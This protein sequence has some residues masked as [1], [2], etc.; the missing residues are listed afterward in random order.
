MRCASAS[1]AVKRQ[2]PPTATAHAPEQGPRGVAR[3]ALQR[4][5][6]ALCLPQPLLQVRRLPAQLRLSVCPVSGCRLLTRARLCQG[7]T[8]LGFA[9]DCGRQRLGALPAGRAGGGG[10]GGRVKWH[11]IGSG[12]LHMGRPPAHVPARCNTLLPPRPATHRADCCAVC[13]RAAAASLRAASSATAAAPRTRCISAS[14]ASSAAASW[15]STASARCVCCA[16]RPSSLPTRALSL[17]LEGK[18]EGGVTSTVGGASS[19][20]PGGLTGSATVR[21][22]QPTLPSPPPR[23][24]AHLSASASRSC[25]RT[26]RVAA[27]SS[28]LRRDSFSPSALQNEVMGAACCSSGSAQCALLAASASPDAAQ[29]RAAAATRTQLGHRAHCS[30]AMYSSFSASRASLAPVP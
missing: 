23:N 4:L 20:C 14:A 15:R 19:V 16:S 8:Q 12:H 25:A 26:R 9:L 30:C 28:P 5:R 24:P 6:R 22:R 10:D 11:T 13:V 18:S 17:S 29:G 27:S 1:A 3:A 21:R 7:R 2:P